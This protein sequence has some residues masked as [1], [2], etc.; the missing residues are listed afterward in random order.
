MICISCIQLKQYLND[1]FGILPKNGPWFCKL[2]HICERRKKNLACFS[3]LSLFLFNVSFH[4]AVRIGVNAMLHTD[5]L[6][7]NPM[8]LHVCHT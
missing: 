2:H 6:L 1:A 4:K 5:T 3:F 8:H 7:H